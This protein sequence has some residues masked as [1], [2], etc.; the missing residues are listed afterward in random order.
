[1]QFR[2]Q[3]DMEYATVED[4][5]T[6]SRQGSLLATTIGSITYGKPHYTATGK[7]SAAAV[8]AESGVFAISVVDEN[9]VV[10]ITDNTFLGLSAAVLGLGIFMLMGSLWYHNARGIPTSPSAA[11]KQRLMMETTTHQ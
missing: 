2:T 7:A 4:V 3:T 10:V 1:M 6:A 8:A 9:N 11:L 5:I